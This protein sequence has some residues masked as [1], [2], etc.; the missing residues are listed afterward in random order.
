[1]ATTRPRAGSQANNSQWV[2]LL[3]ADKMAFKSFFLPSC[4]IITDGRS[5]RGKNLAL[6]QL[7]YLGYSIDAV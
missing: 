7:R 6:E 4:I 2:R 5:D 3:S 1:M